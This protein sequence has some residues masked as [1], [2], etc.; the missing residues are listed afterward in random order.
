MSVWFKPA[1]VGEE[2]CKLNQHHFIFTHTRTLTR[3]CIGGLVGL[4]ADWLSPILKL[5]V[6]E[7]S[8]CIAKHLSVLS[9]HPQ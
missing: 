1:A 3:P 7:S 2:G 4:A 9:E 8:G 5:A 6:D